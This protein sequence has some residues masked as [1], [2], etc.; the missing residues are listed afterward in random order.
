MKEQKGIPIS[1]VV[2]LSVYSSGP[3]V[4]V[5]SHRGRAA[6]VRAIYLSQEVSRIYILVVYVGQRQL[7]DTVNEN[8]DENSRVLIDPESNIR[9]KLYIL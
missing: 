5:I 2:N 6:R 7:K 4:V 8:V 1:T 3:V 9:R